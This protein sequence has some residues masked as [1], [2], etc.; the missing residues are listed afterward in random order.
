[1]RLITGKKL[2]HFIKYRFLIRKHLE[3]YRDANYSY[4]HLSNKLYHWTKVLLY[5]CFIYNRI[6]YECFAKIKKKY[7]FLHLTFILFTFIIFYILCDVYI[8]YVTD[9]F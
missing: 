5:K 8:L 4:D 1:M 9:L 6:F 7:F 3:I 2:F